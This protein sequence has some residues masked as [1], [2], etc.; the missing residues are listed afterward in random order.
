MAS[1]GRCSQFA[2]AGH[3]PLSHGKL[4][5]CPISRPAESFRTLAHKFLLGSSFGL[6]FVLYGRII[7][8]RE[9]GIAL[10]SPAS[11]THPISL[12][13]QTSWR[14]RKV[15]RRGA[16]KESEQIRAGCP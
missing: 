11:E 15:R 5:D 9:F 12:A 2:G 8:I 1:S 3:R 6:T 14:Q 7:G 16:G 10:P 13:L 4:D